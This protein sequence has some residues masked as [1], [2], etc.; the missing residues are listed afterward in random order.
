MHAPVSLARPQPPDQ[1]LPEITPARA[2]VARIQAALARLGFSPGLI[3]GKPGRKTQL[4]IQH[5]QRSRDLPESG[6]ADAPTLDALDCRN[7]AWT[8]SYTVTRED[9]ELI[10]GP[11]PEDW[12]ERAALEH[13]GYENWLDLLAERGWCSQELLRLL[14]PHQAWDAVAPGDHVILPDVPAPRDAKP[15]PRLDH[16]QIL[17]SEKL[18]VG[19]DKNAA[20]ACMFHCSIARLA[21][22]RP[23]GALH[24]QV[25]ALD[26]DYTFNPADWPEV[27]GVDSKLRIAPG[28]RNPVGAAWIGLD[29][30][31]YGMH[32]TVRPQDIGKTGSHGCF[33]LLNWDAVRLAKA[34]RIGLEVR[35]S[36]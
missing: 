12:N 29:K 21:E 2:Q 23:V 4:A 11:I 3:D 18:V 17:L 10:T 33:R 25:V 24:V 34:V 7:P 30:P 27:Q 15:L 9:S 6:E 36:E 5:F 8:R 1:Q 22:K 26:P 32:G 28:P 13:S 19:F 16:I 31:G 35:V 14:N 20:P